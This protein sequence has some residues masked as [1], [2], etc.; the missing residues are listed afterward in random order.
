MLEDV[1]TLDLKV[2]YENKYLSVL[3]YLFL[4]Y[5]TYHLS[6]TIP[7]KDYSDCNNTLRFSFM[8]APVLYLNVDVKQAKIV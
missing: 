4:L 6:P 8:M 5:C 7:H 1:A 3:I 2:T